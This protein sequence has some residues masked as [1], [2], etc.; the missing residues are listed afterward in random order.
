MSRFLSLFVAVGIAGCGGDGV[1]A[2]ASP[3][4]EPQTE[5]GPSGNQTGSLTADDH[6]PGFF[7][8]TYRLLDAQSLLDA[9]TA[10]ERV[11]LELGRLAVDPGELPTM[12]DLDIATL[13]GLLVLEVEDEFGDGIHSLIG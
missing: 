10:A 3:E 4:L 2:V 11:Q 13:E 12:L 1:V 5:P 7:R 8:N 9:G 6:T